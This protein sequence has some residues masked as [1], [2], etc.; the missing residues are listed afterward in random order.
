ME[1]NLIL[2]VLVQLETQFATSA[3]R[4]A[5]TVAN[6]CQHVHE[7]TSDSQEPDEDLDV[8]YLDAIESGKGSTW[9]VTID[10]NG[11]PVMFKIDTGA[12]VTAVTQET[13]TKLG[14]VVLKSATKYLCGPDRKPLKVLGK[15]T[16]SLSSTHHKFDQEVYV[17]QQLKHNLLAL[18]A[19]QQLHLLAQ[20]NQINQTHCPKISKP[21]HRARI[22][23]KTV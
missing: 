21:F 16:V 14:N 17:L 2:A 18:P 9:N 20:V 10:L 4:R 7:M 8:I 5:T 11:Q 6:V 1:T 22:F 23:Y 13:L 12:E 15:L 19:I 3:R